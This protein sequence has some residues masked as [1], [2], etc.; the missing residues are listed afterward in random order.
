MGTVKGGVGKGA[1]HGKVH[2]K[3]A[4]D[5]TVSWDTD[6]TGEWT[7]TSISG[8]ECVLKV[9]NP[10]PDSKY[11]F[12]GWS[13][14]TGSSTTSRE[15][16]TSS[17]GDLILLAVF[18]RNFSITYSPGSGSGT[19]STV[20]YKENVDDSAK[21]KS[22]SNLG[23][24]KTGYSFLNWTCGSS[25]FTANHK[26]AD[27][28]STTHNTSN[29]LTANWIAD[30]Y[31]ITVENNGG[32]GGSGTTYQYSSG[33]QSKTITLPTFA[34]HYISSWTS[35]LSGVTVSGNTVTIPAGALTD[36]TLTPNWA[37]GTYRVTFDP[38]QGTGGGY[39]DVNHP[40][41]VYSY[42]APTR[43]GYTFHSWNS[44]SDGTGN[45]FSAHVPVSDETW[46]A[47][48]TPNTITISFD[49]HDGTSVQ[50]VTGS[51][52]ATVETSPV[53]TRTWHRIRPARSGCYP[54]FRRNGRICTC[55]AKYPFQLLNYRKRDRLWHTRHIWR[56]VQ[57]R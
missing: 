34:G 45:T 22:V 15:K 4:H 1:S 49:S 17:G 14:G 27:V 25:N 46:Y 51:A 9:S 44:K 30:N 36:F 18:G 10:R 42:P 37:H 12:F 35:T 39:Y 50:P 56:T 24:S 23:F 57:G 5:G 21:L 55:T 52:S 38:N 28:L 20:N 31:S 16:R 7:T 41:Y 43:A 29:T 47:K 13:D 48:W 33:S 8:E 6:A 19:S 26:A 40:N 53:T 3:Y 11:T 54:N 32:S 2:I